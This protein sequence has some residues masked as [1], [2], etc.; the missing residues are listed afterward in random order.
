MRWVVPRRVLIFFVLWLVVACRFLP[1]LHNGAHSLLLQTLSLRLKV[2]ELLLVRHLPLLDRSRASSGFLPTLWLGASMVATRS[3]GHCSTLLLQLLLPDLL[4]LLPGLLQLALLG[5]G[6]C[7]CL[8]FMK[9]FPLL[10]FL[11]FL[12]CSLLFAFLLL[13]VEFLLF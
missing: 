6:N 4:L 12:A 8:S 13:S 9:F 5:F 1:S 7:S 10:L 11:L 2:C 3:S